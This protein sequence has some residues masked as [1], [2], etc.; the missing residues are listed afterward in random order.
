MI[1]I[2]T[3]RIFIQRMLTTLANKLYG[4]VHVGFLGGASSKKLIVLGFGTIKP[5]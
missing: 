2:P 4:E 3:S 5:L 1:T